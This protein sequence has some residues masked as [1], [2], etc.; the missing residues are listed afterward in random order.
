MKPRSTILTLI[1]AVCLCVGF[2]S[3]C[4]KTQEIEGETIKRELDPKPA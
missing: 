1:M 2:F 3:A 4:G